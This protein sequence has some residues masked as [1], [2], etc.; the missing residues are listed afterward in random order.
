MRRS[1]FNGTNP[2]FLFKN[3]DFLLRNP[4]FLLKNVDFP[5]FKKQA[6]M[7]EVGVPMTLVTSRWLL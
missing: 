7:A 5:I 4:D 2:D 6:R 1:V 3:P